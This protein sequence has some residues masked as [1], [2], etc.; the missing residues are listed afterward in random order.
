MRLGRPLLPFVA[1][2]PVVGLGGM[3][4]FGA[5]G[6]WSLVWWMAG[7]LSLTVLSFS[8]LYWATTRRITLSLMGTANFNLTDTDLSMSR[9][10]RGSSVMPWKMFK[11]AKRDAKNLLLFFSNRAA[12]V[13]PLSSL[14]EAAISFVIARVPEGR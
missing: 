9:Q 7:L 6:V 8:Y 1:L 14:S 12:V 13:I 10:D 2:T 5:V 11:F 3:V 4:F